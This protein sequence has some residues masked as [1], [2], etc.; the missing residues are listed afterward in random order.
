MRQAPA[1][2]RNVSAAVALAALV[3]LSSAGTAGADWLVTKDGGR[4][5]TKGPWR[6]EGR[7]VLFTTEDTGALASL[8]LADVDLAASERATSDAK[9]A[10]AAAAAAKSQPE[11]PKKAVRS[12]TDKDFSHST[13]TTEG[14]GEA[15]ETGEGTAGP[16]AAPSTTVEVA[17]WSSETRSESRQ[18][19]I[20]G[21]VRNN[22]TEVAT[23]I[24]VSVRLISEQGQLLDTREAQV[25]TRALR[26]GQETTFEATFTD[27]LTFADAAFEVKS[28][29][30]L[31]RPQ[32]A[33]ST[34]PTPSTGS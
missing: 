31:T 29:P 1:P 34:P 32:P 17:E 6:V 18:V 11:A 20:K 22:G 25:L 4:V 12:F 14:T 28:V 7:R 2:N 8:R 27:V 26:P 23:A 30:L 10:A 16:E 9:T 15:G 13:P 5:E 19:V 24:A 33:E 3:A 21:R